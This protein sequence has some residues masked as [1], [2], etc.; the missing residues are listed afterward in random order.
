MPSLKTT[1]SII[2][3]CLITHTTLERPRDWMSQQFINPS[4]AHIGTHW[5]CGSAIPTY[6]FCAIRKIIFQHPTTIFIILTSLHNSVAWSWTNCTQF[7]ILKCH[8]IVGTCLPLCLQSVQSSLLTLQSLSVLNLTILHRAACGRVKLG[9]PGIIGNMPGIVSVEFIG[10]RMGCIGGL[11]VGIVLF[12]GRIG[13][14][15]S[16]GGKLSMGGRCINC[17]VVNLPQS[18]HFSL[19]PIGFLNSWLSASLQLAGHT[20]RLETLA[21]SK[22]ETIAI[23]KSLQFST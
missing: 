1:H 11:P 4:F 18:Q 5:S 9:M 8:Y 16:K 23:S 22:L 15:W 20:G 19:A 3:V 2:P 14:M 17:C 10:G 21:I 13:D 6:H 7:T 12:V